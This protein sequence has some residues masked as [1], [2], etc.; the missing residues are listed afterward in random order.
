[1]KVK[2][3]ILLFDG[4][5]KFCNF[6]VGLI[7]RKKAQHKFIYLALES[8][9]GKE[10]RFAHKVDLSIDSVLVIDSDKVYDKSSA[11]FKIAHTL[12]GFWN[13]TFVFWLIPK[14]L[15]NW[16]YDL[17]AKNR[18]LFFKNRNSCELHN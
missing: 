12:G 9:E 10:L 17:I 14:P 2:K 7:Q 8:K 5:C 18:H 6:W 11:A 4:E 16:L 3:L 15:R 1:M 13:L